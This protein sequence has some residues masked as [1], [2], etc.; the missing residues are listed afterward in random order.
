MT[1]DAEQS[2]P[3][4]L[5]EAN[6]TLHAAQ[7]QHALGGESFEKATGCSQPL[8]FVLQG[9]M[10]SRRASTGVWLRNAG[11]Q[12]RNQR[13]RNFD[14]SPHNCGFRE[15]KHCHIWASSLYGFVGILF[16]VGLQGKTKEHTSCRGSPI[17][18]RTH[19]G[20]LFRGQTWAGACCM[21]IRTPSAAVRRT[22]TAAWAE[23]AAKA[24]RV[25][26]EAKRE[27][28]FDRLDPTMGPSL[29][30]PKRGN[31]NPL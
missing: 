4:S 21:W 10:V 24:L 11:H 23:L 27:I 18:R 5:V 30:E 20:T 28:H 1:R 19:N 2:S 15:A 25:Q 14:T 22:A 29:Q 9:C 17:L 26:T 6:P 8:V 12:K 31:S 16:G 7:T 3:V 13:S